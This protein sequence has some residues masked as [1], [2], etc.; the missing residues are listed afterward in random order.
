MSL[1]L[2]LWTPP[3]EELPR[4]HIRGHLSNELGAA[5]ETFNTSAESGSQTSGTPTLPAIPPILLLLVLERSLPGEPDVHLSLFFVVFRQH[6]VTQSLG[7][8]R[9]LKLVHDPGVHHFPVL[10]REPIVG[11]NHVSNGQRADL[12]PVDIRNWFVVLQHVRVV[13]AN[14][15]L[16]FRHVPRIN[17]DPGDRALVDLF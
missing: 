13:D 15:P 16:V 7:A 17:G 8:L 1:S 4:Q 10:I 3:G 5:H 12:R 6:G 14:L 9:I 2:L 11:G